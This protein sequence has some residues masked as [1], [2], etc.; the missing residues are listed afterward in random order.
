MQPGRSSELAELIE[1]LSER[2][3]T[4]VWIK[5]QDHRLVYMNPAFERAFGIAREDWLGKT[6]WD[7]F[8]NA[9]AREMAE[10]D[11]RVQRT[12]VPEEVMETAIT[13][14][15]PSHYRS[16]KIPLPR[17]DG[18]VFLGGISTVVTDQIEAERTLAEVMERQQEE[19]RLRDLLLGVISHDLR[20]PLTTLTSLIDACVDPEQEF[21]ADD[22]LE[23]LPELRERAHEAY[24][25]LEDALAW[26]RLGLA[27]SQAPVDPIDL[28]EISLSVR[29]ALE[30]TG[31]AKDV[32]IDVSGLED[33]EVLAQPGL[34][35]SVLRNVLHNAIKYSPSGGVIR[36]SHSVVG[37]EVLIHVDDEGEGIDDGAVDRLEHG[38]FHIPRRGTGG[39]MGKGI[40]LALSIG[41]LK[42]VGAGLSA[43]R[44]PEGGTRVT[45]HVRHPGVPARLHRRAYVS[46]ATRPLEASEFSLLLRR[47]RTRNTAV[48]I[49]GV[50]LYSGTQFLHVIEGPPEAVEET[51]ERVSQDPRHE[52]IRVLIDEPISHS[53]YSGW[54]MHF[55][56][57]DDHLVEAVSSGDLRLIDHLMEGPRIE[58]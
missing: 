35:L 36:L 33:V 17:P 18:T 47:A 9:L 26:V 58:A 23:L 8:P 52:D 16:W 19:A 28:H 50:L 57:I 1:S 37:S 30:S 29:D 22:L 44:R 51:F 38:E 53:G 54:A 45:V 42:R 27:A 3:P 15:L 14:G 21:D 24:G 32:S 55:V 40:G 6:G 7:L 12:Q 10:N 43:D 39:E 5:D 11:H 31:L 56:E 20:G 46:R 4:L 48:G 34:M 13:D 25:L 49:G 2:V 41:L